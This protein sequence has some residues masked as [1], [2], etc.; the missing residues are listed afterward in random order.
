M[1]RIAF[2]PAIP[3]L[4]F[5]L[6]FLMFADRALADETVESFKRLYQET[7]HE[8]HELMEMA[9]EAMTT[10][11]FNLSTLLPPVN[12]LMEKADGLEKLS[13]KIGR[14][15]GEDEARQMKRYLSRLK[16]AVE[17]RGEKGEIV[18]HIASYYLHFNN[19]LMVHTLA[20]KDVLGDHLDELKGALEQQYTHKI[21][22]VSEHFYVH[23]N[24]MYYAAMIFGKKIWQK[25]SDS[26]KEDADKLIAAAEAGDT[27]T[28]RKLV[29]DME[30][31]IRTLQKI[32]T[33]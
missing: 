5:A 14:K 13:A 26:I 12:T 27:T 3:S 20:L 8:T 32:V 9:G 15:E 28:M 19:L 22:H 30:M 7:G 23:A 1:K 21:A 11:E 25:F 33:E 24:Q 6:L 4:F 10:P 16:T 31:P 18:A 29:A 17:G 2:F